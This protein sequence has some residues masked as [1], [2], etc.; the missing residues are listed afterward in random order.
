M[1]KTILICDECECEIENPAY[2]AVYNL[3]KV[4]ITECVSATRTQQDNIDTYSKLHFCSKDCIE[5]FFLNLARDIWDAKYPI[6]CPYTKG[7]CDYE[8]PE[9]KGYCEGCTRETEETR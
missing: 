6:I 9:G 5:Q 8:G 3:N 2:V 1:E 7:L 4:V